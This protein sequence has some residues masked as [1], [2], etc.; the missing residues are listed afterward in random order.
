[1]LAQF[2]NPNFDASQPITRPYYPVQDFY[3]GHVPPYYYPFTAGNS[4]VQATQSQPQVQTQAAES[5]QATVQLE[6]RKFKNTKNTEV[7]SL[8]GLVYF[9]NDS[10]QEF[11]C[12]TCTSTKLAKVGDE[13]R[14][15]GEHRHA[16]D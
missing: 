2:E 5:R 10:R 12:K 6:P 1:M 4:N 16:P 14:I 13:W 3:P 8:N 11:R 15:F 7:L 9:W